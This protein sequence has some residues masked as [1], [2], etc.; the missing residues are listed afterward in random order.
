MDTPL[1][2]TVRQFGPLVVD[3][4]VHVGGKA[5]G[6]VDDFSEFFAIDHVSTEEVVAHEATV[7]VFGVA[8]GEQD[9]VDHEV[10]ASRVHAAVFL[11]LPSEG[12]D[13]FGDGGGVGF[14]GGVSAIA[15]HLFTIEVEATVIPVVG[16]G[17]TFTEAEEV[18]AEDTVGGH[19][20]DH[21]D[22]GGGV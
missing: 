20:H 15:E 7:G 10:V 5:G 8:E 22:G 4:A 13:T 3:V 21:G 14:P 2:F 1:V 17:R 18:E 6:E 12:V 11:I 16:V 9:V 19:I